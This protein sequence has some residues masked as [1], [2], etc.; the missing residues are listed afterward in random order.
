MWDGSPS[1]YEGQLAEGFGILASAIDRRHAGARAVIQAV[2]LPGR[3]DL[4]ECDEPPLGPSD[5]AVRMAYAG[6]CGS[7]L[8]VL[9]DPGDL[10]VDLAPGIV[11]GH[12]WSGVVD[13]VG[14]AVERVAPGMRVHGPAARS[15]A[16][17]ARACL[18]AARPRV[19][20]GGGRRRARG[21]PGRPG[22][23]LP[24]AAS[25][26]RHA[27][28]RRAH[29]AVRLLA[30]GRGARERAA[31]RSRAGHRGRAHRPPRGA[32]GAA[33]RGRSRGRLRAV[34]VP[35]RARGLAGLRGRETRRTDRP[36][37]SSSRWSTRP[38]AAPRP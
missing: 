22:P 19:G 27:P 37:S 9:A 28:R 33:G 7:E 12:E 13:A 1:G 17:R 21:G 20:G 30:A 25:R 4:R 6:I 38:S 15:P 3:F 32:R 31:G 24:R 26:R 8:H 36:A 11:F 29:R 23:G 2:A 10:G 5:V 16:R 14:S 35:A 34:G 18:P